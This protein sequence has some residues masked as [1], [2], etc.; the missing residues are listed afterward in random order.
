MPR[1]ADGNDKCRAMGATPIQGDTS[2]G[3]TSRKTAPSRGFRHRRS[4]WPWEKGYICVAAATVA[5]SPA[6]RMNVAHMRL[7]GAAILL[8]LPTCGGV[9]PRN[10]T[11]SHREGRE[12]TSGGTRGRKSGRRKTLS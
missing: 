2:G 10:S 9:E 7:T 6:T 3:Y 11:R 12:A 5:L 8:V 1:R 4:G